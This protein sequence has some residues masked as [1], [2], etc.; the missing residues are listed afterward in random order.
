MAKPLIPVDTIYD[1]ALEV[2]E[3]EGVSALN[4]RNLTARLHCSTQTLYQQV[5]KRDQMI[6][7]VVRHAFARMELDFEPGAEAGETIRRW[8]TTLRAELLAHP[9]LTTLMT[10]EDRVVVEDYGAHLITALRGHGFSKAQ[11]V[12]VAGIISH[13]TVSMTHSDILAPGP[14]DRPEVFE[15]AVEWLVEGMLGTS[16]RVVD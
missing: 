8:A 16:Q 12:R 5:G 9:A 6:R 15:T 13:I 10:V 14:W 1:A 4:A 2:L 7:G 11:S 3:T